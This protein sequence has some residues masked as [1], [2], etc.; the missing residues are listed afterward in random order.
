[1]D[2][3]NLFRILEWIFVAFGAIVC[4]GVVILFA[5]QPGQRLWPLPGIYFSEILLV[6]A[7]AVASLI[8]KN[9]ANPA[10]WQALPWVAGGVLFSFVI[11]GAFS[12]GLFLSPAMLAFWLAG[13]FSDRRL[14]INMASHIA[15]ALLS[16]L[17]Q[18]F[19]ILLISN[20]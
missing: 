3:P 13:V 19:L 2:K 10:F 7:L 6:S 20:V 11:A 4:A 17:F 14:N 18:V 15:I 16:A 1:M 12:I 8:W 9:T 5:S